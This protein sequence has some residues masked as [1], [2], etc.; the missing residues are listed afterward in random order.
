MPGAE[1]SSSG[2][3]TMILR[4]KEEGLPLLAALAVGTPWV[5]LTETGDTYRTNGLTT[6]S[7]ATAVIWAAQHDFMPT[8]RDTTI[9]IRE[10]PCTN[11]ERE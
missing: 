8:V 7:S 6:F 11:L 2:I 4:A 1:L 3:P 10:I 9:I 5:D